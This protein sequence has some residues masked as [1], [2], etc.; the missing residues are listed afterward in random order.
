MN[1]DPKLRKV[2][3]SR[4]W[5]KPKPQRD[6]EEAELRDRLLAMDMS[7]VVGIIIGTA[8][9]SEHTDDPTTKMVLQFAYYKICDTLEQAGHNLMKADD[10]E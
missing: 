3:K 10:N 1:I 8:A 6:Q 9:M 2:L 5:Q 4:A 7:E